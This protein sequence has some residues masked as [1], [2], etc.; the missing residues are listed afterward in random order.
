MNTN[1]EELIARKI[2]VRQMRARQTWEKKVR[3]I[4]Q[5]KSIRQVAF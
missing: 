2:A 4:E 5:M 1:F 3:L